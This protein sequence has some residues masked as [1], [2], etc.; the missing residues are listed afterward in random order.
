MIWN[1]RRN[2]ERSYIWYLLE[3]VKVL[4]KKDFSINI[5]DD[6]IHLIVGEERRLP[7]FI[8]IIL[9]KYGV[10][11]L[12]DDL[13]KPK[14]ILGRLIQL[15]NEEREVQLARLNPSYF[16]S[17]LDAISHLKSD[18]KDFFINELEKLMRLR[19]YKVL[20]RVYTRNTE[21]LD[22]IEKLIIES[23][24]NILHDILDILPKEGSAFLSHLKKRL[25]FNP[26]LKNTWK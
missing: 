14:K 21:G 9:E 6:N 3:D 8:A 10:V 11:D 2:I 7:R 4:P 24:L 13:S 22:F 19:I 15:V 17:L 25:S 23:I 5:L 16:A 20:H 26:Q 18:K 12:E 1:I